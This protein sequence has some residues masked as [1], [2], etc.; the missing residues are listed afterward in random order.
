M[1][2]VTP[3]TPDPNRRASTDRSPGTPARPVHHA[4]PGA[5]WRQLPFLATAM[6]LS[7]FW[8]LSDAPLSARQL[9]V[10][11]VAT[12]ICAVASI[13]ILQAGQGS[14]DPE[15][16]ITP[17]THDKPLLMTAPALS[18]PGEGASDQRL[19]VSVVIPTYLGREYLVPCLDAV[20]S[21]TRP[22]DQVIVVDDA[23]PDDTAQWVRETYP[24]VDVVALPT[25]RKFAGA[26]NEGIR[27]STGDIVVL[28]NNDTE[29]EPGWLAAL[30]APFEADPEVGFCASKLLLFD[31]RDHLHAAGDGYTVGGIPV[32]RGAFTKDDSRFDAEPWVFGACAAASAYRR[33][34][35]LETGG[36]DEWLVSYL[37]D[38]DLSW[39]AQLRGYR[40]RFVPEARVYHHV[41][42]TG[43]QVRPSY[44]CGR[45][46]LLVLARDMPAPLLRRHWR[47]IIASQG[48]IV[49]DAVRHWR[50]AAARARLRGVVAG[51][52]HL[53]G[54]IAQR[55]ALHTG[56]QIDIEALDRLLDRS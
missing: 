54:A 47:A 13:A 31:R 11:A 48:R 3:S 42:A 23:S 22:A 21:Q 38:I 35:L 56:A 29:A 30:V 5:Y 16:S 45:N 4:L 18:S 2:E 50:G 20:A 41:S 28:L 39:R 49:R 51:L 40:C 53:P 1:P 24:W 15:P 26:A 33:E 46:F 6:L 55:R 44:W 52:W 12:L 8:F 32:N 17:G 36:F 7:L 37:E 27:S 25:N 9:T 19:S 43:G 10:F 34:L 14:P